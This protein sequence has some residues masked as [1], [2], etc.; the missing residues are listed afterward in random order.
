MAH[1]AYPELGESAIE[2]LL[3]ALEAHAQNHAARQ[4]AVLGPSTLNIGTITGGRAPNVIPDEAKAEIFIRLVDDGSATRGSTCEAA[5]GQ[6]AEA[7]RSA[8]QFPPCASAALEGF[9]TTVVAYTTDIPAFGGAWGQPFLFGPGTIHVA[10]TLEERVPKAATP[11]SV[12]TLSKHGRN[13]SSLKGIM[14]T[15]I[16]VG[17]L[18]ATG[19]VGQHFIKF[20]QDHPWFDLTWLGASDR[21]A[22]KKYRDATTWHLD[23]AMPEAVADLDGAGMQ[24]R[25]RAAPAVL[26]HGRL[27]SPPRSSALSPRPA[28]SWSRTRATTAWSAMCRCWCPEINADHLK[29]VPGQQRAR[30]WKGQIVTNP[31]CSTIV[32]THGARRR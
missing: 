14:Q 10:H 25:Q 30:G 21:S 26:R 29:L 17:I 5:V 22:G 6:L 8:L 28:T 16:E 23:G 4:D 13:C 7:A 9:E 24:A 27:A 32:L 19:M 18:G 20:L 2:K 1:S 15:R 12:Q 31:N 3:D 11:R